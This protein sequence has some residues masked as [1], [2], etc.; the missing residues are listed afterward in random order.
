[1]SLCDCS[2]IHCLKGRYY[3]LFCTG[4]RKGRKNNKLSQLQRSVEGEW[5]QATACCNRP[6]QMLAEAPSLHRAGSMATLKGPRLKGI[7][8]QAAL[9]NPEVQTRSPIQPMGNHIHPLFSVESDI[10]QMTKSLW[11]VADLGS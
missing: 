6:G 5:K 4:M 2:F 1:M 3:S 11:Q 7:I 10:T 8:L 9:P